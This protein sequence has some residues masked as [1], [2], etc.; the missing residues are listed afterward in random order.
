MSSRKYEFNYTHICKSMQLTVAIG[1]VDCLGIEER[2]PYSLTHVVLV[3]GVPGLHRVASAV[4]RSYLK[5][6]K[7]GF[8]RG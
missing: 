6:F 4:P 1:V 2:Q 7:Q 3:K 8:N 5:G